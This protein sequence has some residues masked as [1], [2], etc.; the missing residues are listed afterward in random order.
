MYIRF[1]APLQKQKIKLAQNCI[2]RFLYDFVKNIYVLICWLQ[3]SDKQLRSLGSSS[4]YRKIKWNTNKDVDLEDIK[5]YV[6]HLFCFNQ[7]TFHWSPLLGESSR[8]ANHKSCNCSMFYHHEWKP[9]PNLCELS[10]RYPQ[11]QDKLC[12]YKLDEPTWKCILYQYILTLWSSSGMDSSLWCSR[13][14][15]KKE[16]HTSSSSW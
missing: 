8:L 1:W 11:I 12:G 2:F 3:Y 5:N 4:S 10:L 7:R 16:L 9:V 14:Y 15:Q 13:N 6:N